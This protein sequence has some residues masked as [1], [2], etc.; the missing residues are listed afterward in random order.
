MHLV[1]LKIGLRRLVKERTSAAI[2]ILSLA[3][4]IASF[5][6]LGIYA[7]YGTAYDKHHADFDRIFRVVQQEQR[8]EPFYI[9]HR[10]L[11]GLAL[12]PLLARDH[13]ELEEYLRIQPLVPTSYLLRSADKAFYWDDVV[14]ADNNLFNFFPHEIIAGDPFSA[15]IEPRSIAINESVAAAYFGNENAIGKIVRND[16]GT[17]FRVTLVFRDLPR[18]LISST[19]PLF[20]EVC[21]MLSI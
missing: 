2:A 14:V 17:D 11:T 19:L 8:A 21:R 20:P 5:I 6:I 7:L 13:R 10:P 15:L 18:T 4:G 3:I 12:G 16:L 1:S 9:N